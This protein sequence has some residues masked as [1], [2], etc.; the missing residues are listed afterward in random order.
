MD[1]QNG[2]K[3]R[4][5][6]LPE[7][8]AGEYIWVA[9]QRLGMA[10]SGFGIM[11]L[12]WAEIDAY[13]RNSQGWIGTWEVGLIHDMSVAYLAGYEAGKDPLGISPWED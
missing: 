6:P 7:L 12:A 13:A 11:P 5:R 4:P 8:V 1:G 9:W 2:A 3:R 10:Q